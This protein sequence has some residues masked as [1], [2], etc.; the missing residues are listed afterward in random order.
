MES[1]EDKDKLLLR[2]EKNADKSS[3]G[4]EELDGTYYDYQEILIQMGYILLFGLAF[5]L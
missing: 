4:Y 3:Y 5:P 2:I 1:K